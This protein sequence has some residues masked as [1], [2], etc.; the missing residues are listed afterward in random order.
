MLN[1]ISAVIDG[2]TEVYGK[3]TDLSDR[4]II[5]FDKNLFTNATKKVVLL[6]KLFTA[7]VGDEG[8]FMQASDFE[9]YS[10]YLTYFKEREDF[11]YFHKIKLTPVFACKTKNF[12]YLGTV[13]GMPCD[14]DIN[15]KKFGNTYTLSL[16]YDLTKIKIYE[17]FEVVLF[18]LPLTATFKEM[19]LRYR[20]YQINE[21]G[22][23]PLKKRVEENEHIKY[24]QN[25]IEIRIRQGW[26]PA[27]P[28]V[29][30][31]TEENEPPMRVACTFKR[32]RDIIDSLVLE[33][34]KNV[35]LCL[36]G[37][38]KSGH[39][40]RWPDAFPVEPL[41]GG[42][43]ELAKTIAYAKSVG[44]KIVCHTNVT[45]IYTI[46]KKWNGGEPTVKNI[47]GEIQMNESPWSGGNMYDLCPA[48][49]LGVCKDTFP[50][51][52]E[53]GFEG[54]HYIDVVSIVHP[55]S[56]FDKNHPVNAR[57]SVELYKEVA[58]YTR[59]TFGAFS[60]EGS[61]DYYVPFLDYGLYV[62]FNRKRHPHMDEGVPF[63][64]MVFHGL[65]LY[66][67]GSN[68]V[69]LPF[70]TVEDNLQQIEFGGRNSF[71]YYSNFHKSHIWMG[72]TDL[73]AD[74]DEQMVESAKKVKK[75][76]D[77]YMNLCH[78]QT[79]FINDYEVLTPNVRVVTYSNNEK[80]AVNYSSD[81]Y[82]LPNGLTVKAKNY[83]LFK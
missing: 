79:E 39:D 2:K 59:D 27:P 46:S 32:V 62:K 58:N 69:N 12:C 1:K 21:V 26:K 4:L 6:E 63:Y 15:I 7:N 38:N 23:V 20:E 47:K 44:Y 74:T 48:K 34:V 77:E 78:L 31:Q 19:A 64:E 82:V 10:A 51:L 81:D 18:K 35:Q 45:D 37:W 41:L 25:S 83:L 13:T 67:Q 40:G 76:Y 24:M 65:V 28:T 16:V 8:F 75:Y 42:E 14:H 43:E 50:K 61:F 30:E 11:D 3:V 55:R 54:S 73:L 71:Y 66:N 17:D 70:K 68:T 72:H 49:A 52:K 29:L 5:T 56:C 36:V 60:S 9:R 80:I 22:C 33:G 57:Q 53:L